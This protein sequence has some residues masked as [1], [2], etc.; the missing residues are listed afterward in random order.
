MAYRKFMS[1]KINICGSSRAELLALVTSLGEKPFR[2]KQL[3]HQLYNRGASNFTEMSNLSKEFREKLA[4]HCIIKRPEIV[5][6][7]QAEDGT[8]KWLLKFDDG[9]QVEMVF[10]P[11]ED[12]G[13]LCIS[14]Q[15]GCNMGCKFCHTGTMR[16]IR[17]LTHQEIIAQI[18]I[19]R[20]CYDEWPSP[21]DGNRLISNIVVMGMGEPLDNYDNT[22]I[23]LETIMDAE[24]IAI[25]KRR[26]TLST[27]GIIPK[28]HQCGEELGVN[29]AISLHAPNDALRSEIMPINYKYS[30]KELIQACKDYPAAN[31]ARRI[32][33]EYIMIDGLNDQPEHARELI[34][35]IKG[36]HAKFNLI[37]FNPW[38]GS[39]YRPSSRNAQ[40]RFAR[41]L[42][43]AGYSAPIRVTRGEDIDAACG[44]LNT[45]YQNQS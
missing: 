12:R 3:F 19:A 34:T 11:E 22:K 13:A 17:N 35:L 41:I 36:V 14:T 37:P 7:Q 24:G 38:E 45:K 26:I 43:D 32:T 6:M 30:L 40:F 42:N 8:C 4:A 9:N 2:A 20:D 29:L 39:V 10:I 18:L 5:A 33:F 1:D 23:A 27:C 44:Q 28:I 15:V 31:N 21:N 16:V 25:S